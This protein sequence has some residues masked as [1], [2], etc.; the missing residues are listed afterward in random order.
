MRLDQNEIFEID[1]AKLVLQLRT[2]RRAI[3][4][5]AEEMEM[6][7]IERVF[8]QSVSQ[9]LTRTSRKLYAIAK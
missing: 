9:A 4:E 3:N 5:S 1:R 2:I 7:A 8:V 6:V